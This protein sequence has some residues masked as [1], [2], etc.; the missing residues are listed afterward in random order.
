MPPSVLTS[1]IMKAAMNTTDRKTR[2]G[3]VTSMR[4]IPSQDSQSMPIKRT[5]PLLHHFNTWSKI[6]PD[7]R[8]KPQQLERLPHFTRIPIEGMVPGFKR[9]ATKQRR[10]TLTTA[11]RKL[12]QGQPNS[13]NLLS[14]RSF[15]AVPF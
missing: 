13:S 7:G 15:P 14:K 12:Q 1:A 11:K 2:Q 4:D 10:T 3:G 8:I 5:N 6:R 9:Q